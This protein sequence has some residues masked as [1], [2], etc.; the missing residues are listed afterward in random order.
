ME[1]LTKPTANAAPRS[2]VTAEAIPDLLA[3]MRTG[4]RRA[5]AS[6]VT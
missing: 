2:S 3:R 6:A 5:I 1:N 4:E